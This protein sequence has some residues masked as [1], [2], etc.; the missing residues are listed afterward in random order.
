MASKKSAK[1]KEDSPQ[2]NESEIKLKEEI[3]EKVL[4]ISTLR[5]AVTRCKISRLDRKR[6]TN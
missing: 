4:A 6:S 2:L 3:A 1:G 5:E